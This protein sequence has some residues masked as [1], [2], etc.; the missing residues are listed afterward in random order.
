M[1]KT[2]YESLKDLRYVK[3]KTSSSV[4]SQHDIS[5]FFDIYHVDILKENKIIK[6]FDKKATNEEIL[7]FIDENINREETK[8]HF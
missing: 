5:V 3:E 2:L 4:L 8:W 6:T 1:T 7:S